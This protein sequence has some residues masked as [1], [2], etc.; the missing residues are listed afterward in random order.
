MPPLVKE[1]VGAI[2]DTAVRRWTSAKRLRADTRARLAR[3]R[4]SRQTKARS[5]RQTLHRGRTAALASLRSKLAPA[6]VPPLLWESWPSQDRP[7][8]TDKLR[9]DV[10]RVVHSHAEG[11]AAVDVG[12]ELGVDWRR[13]LDVGRTLAEGG[14]LDQIDYTFFPVR[15][16]SPTW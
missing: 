15:K 11:I 9:A 6:L 7:A 16:A 5:M 10:L 12:N 4:A 14:L 2:R 13:V 8:A 1:I 3:Q